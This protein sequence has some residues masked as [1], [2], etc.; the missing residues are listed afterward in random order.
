[1]ALMPHNAIPALPVAI[2]WNPFGPDCTDSVV[3]GS[4]IHKYESI[5]RIGL[6]VRIEELVGQAIDSLA[7]VTEILEK[8]AYLQT[9][10]LKERKYRNP[11]SAHTVFRLYTVCG[12]IFQY[13]AL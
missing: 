11:T 5:S 7:T 1:M 13:Y 8:G 4:I 9:I 3:V 6:L 2:A 12:R 10:L